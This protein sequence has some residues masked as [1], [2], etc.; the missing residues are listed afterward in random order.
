MAY[1]ITYEKTLVKT[2]VLPYPSD[3]I[4]QEKAI[5]DARTQADKGLFSLVQNEVNVFGGKFA[6]NYVYTSVIT[7]DLNGNN[8]VKATAKMDIHKRTDIIYP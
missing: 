4:G 2:V 6:T 7:Q 3:T 5:S 1:N 8:V